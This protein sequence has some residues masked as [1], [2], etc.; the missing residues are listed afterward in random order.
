MAVTS[1]MVLF[2]VVWFMTFLMALPIG[3][4]TQGDERDIVPGTHAGAPGHHN[5]KRKAL[6]TTAVTVVV[7]GVLCCII[8]SGRIS[9]DDIEAFVGGNPA[10]RSYETDE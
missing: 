5:L 10:T 3:T 7:W 6:W 2:A 9:V 4:R 1:A 8:I